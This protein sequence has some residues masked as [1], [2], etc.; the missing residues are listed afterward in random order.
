VTGFWRTKLL[1]GNERTLEENERTLLRASKSYDSDVP[2]EKDDWHFIHTFVT[3]DTL[4]TG[5]WHTLLFIS[6]SQVSLL[7]INPTPKPSC[8][9]IL[10]TMRAYMTDMLAANDIGANSTV[11][12]CEDNAKIP[13]KSR[14]PL[15][16]QI[17]ISSRW[18]AI[19]LTNDEDKLVCPKRKTSD[20]DMMSY[21][22]QGELLPRETN[23]YVARTCLNRMEMQVATGRPPLV[24]P[25]S[26]SPRR[27]SNATIDES[28]NGDSTCNPHAIILSDSGSRPHMH[29]N[30]RKRANF[31][32]GELSPC[33]VV[34]SPTMK[35]VEEARRRI[36][37]YP[38]RIVFS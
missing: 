29:E 14:S 23:Q 25:G 33:T 6:A 12:I 38:L 9:N 35:G 10:L 7:L 36:P 4:L 17:K 5:N 37:A 24:R 22:S 20:V 31:S 19:S 27:R 21:F 11:I 30:Q 1:Q 13:H 34:N 3:F 26:S 18:D 32:I 15:D 8:P 28:I 16:D 2:N